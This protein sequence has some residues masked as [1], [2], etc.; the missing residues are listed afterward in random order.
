MPKKP[1]KSLINLDLLKPQGEPQ[2]LLVK[3]LRWILSSGRFIII[4]VE[5]LV[6]GAFLFRFKL[7]ADIA[8][9]K[10]AIDEQ[11]PFIESLKSDEDLIRSTQ[12]QIATVQSIREG[13]PEY[14]LIL[15]KI[16]LQ[17]PDGV[18][19][20]SLT[21]QKEVG[22]LDIKISGTAS[23]NG[24]LSSFIVG[25]K[26]ETSFQDIN[27]TSANLEQGLVNFSLTGAAKQPAKNL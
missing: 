6:L 17:T 9:T 22:K 14:S 16:A 13:N 27:L 24:E 5:I 21:L 25:L 15:Q 10:E 2:K 4:F 19:L 11:I 8:Q 3:A 26:K 23:T 20:G 12:F 7:D 18:T 1:A